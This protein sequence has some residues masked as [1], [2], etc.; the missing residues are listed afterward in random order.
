VV[1][2]ANGFSDTLPKDYVVSTNPPAGTALKPGAPVTVVIA[3]G[4]YPVHVPSVVGQQI[5]AARAQLQ[6]AGFQ[7]AVTQQNDPTAPANQV[8][9]QDPPGNQ[10]M[11]SA[12]GVTVTLTI[13]AGPPIPPMPSV[14]GMPCPNAY[15]QLVGM[16][17]QVIIQGDPQSQEFGTVHA[18]SPDPNAPLTAGQQV[19]I[20][21][22]IP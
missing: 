12:D 20:T 11:A 7:V 16:G 1:S 4:P 19:Q 15:G 2:V 21:C 17:L 9:S 10:G 14:L 5:D 6:G 8:L 22:A 13:S 18:Q 3:E